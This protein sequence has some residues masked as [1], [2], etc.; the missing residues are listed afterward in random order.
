M[1]WR[2]GPSYRGWMGKDVHG[3]TGQDI[4]IRYITEDEIPLW[5]RAVARG[6]MRP[7]VADGSEF[8]R[9]QFEPGRWFGAFDES[10]GGRC[11]ATFRSFDTELTVPG[12]AT[13]QVDAIT[14]VT[15]NATHRRRGLLTTMMSRDLEAARERGSA[16]AILIAAEYNIY[17]R[18][19]FGPATR[20]NGWN[21]DL[22]RAGG[23][24]AGLPETPGGRIDF[25]TMEEVRKFGP[26]L[27]ER[28]RLTQPGAIGRTPLWW[29]L[30]TGEVTLP[31][32]DWK[33][34]FA[35]LHRD[36]EGDVTG[37]IV[38]RVDDNWD[39][40]YPNCTL[41]VASFLALDRA[42]ATAL[43]RFALSVD[44]VRK[45]VVEYLGQDDPLPLLLNDPRGATPH[46]EDY[47]FMWL[48]L[49]DVPAAFGARTY[50]APGRVVLQVSDPA[51]YAEGRWALEAA[52]DGT[53]RCTA[54]DDAPDLE[55]GVSELGS[56]YLGAETVSRLA[57][58]SLVTELR[59]GA[60]ADADLLLRTPLR[61]FN[62]D[63]F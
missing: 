15:V 61:A 17:G 36:A 47:D 22:A 25:V 3:R 48:R 9:L 45:V 41:T 37:L 14:G 54:T 29:R 7:H 35:A 30:Q 27:H 19:G 10:D 43:W 50:G 32:F 24:R 11:V 40:G 1:P 63:G 5:D 53:G 31:G 26:E 6:F 55:L 46:A 49:L 18:Y 42:T 58:A 39:G 4:D 13:F 21:I 59:P 56:L 33:E 51:G 57:A 28:W 62:P 60:A 44:W 52:A 20:G 23:L 2:E 8:R 16:A 34:P 38:Y 12:G